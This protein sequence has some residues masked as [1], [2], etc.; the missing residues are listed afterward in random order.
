[1]YGLKR[2][3]KAY[4][5]A[6]FVVMS[7][8]QGAAADEI[9][10]D[11]ERVFG[12]SD[13]SWDTT[14]QASTVRSKTGTKSLAI[15][16]HSA[17]AGLSWRRIAPLATTGYAELRFWIYA[18]NISQLSLTTQ[19][20]DSGN[21]ST[22]VTFKPDANR[23]K[24]IVIPLS[25]LGNPSHIARLTIRNAGTL[26][27]LFYIDQLRLVSNKVQTKLTID[28][29]R[30]RKA[31]SPYIYGMSAYSA[32]SAN[33]QP[34]LKELKLPLLRFGGNHTSRYNWKLDTSN[35][36]ADWFFENIKLSNA[37]NLPA[38]SALNRF[39]NQNK[40]NQSQ[41]LLTIPMLGYLA[42]NDID[43]GFSISQ[44]GLQQ[45]HDVWRTNCGNG[46][47]TD[48]TTVTGNNPID[49]S[50][51]S[52]NAFAR[53]WVDYLKR[54]YGSS[55]ATGVRFYALDNEPDLWHGTHRDVAPNAI[56]Y[57]QLRD[58]TYQYA[59]AIK[60]ADSTAAVLGPVMAGWQSYWQSPY[61]LQNANL[62]PNDRNLHAGTALIPWYLQQM[63]LYEQV[64]GKRILDYLD[65]HYY[66]T[67]AGSI[68]GPVGDAA[69]QVT[70]LRST[71]ALW[72]STYMD[73]S[74]IAD[75]GIQ[76]DGIPAGV[77][78]L[79]PRMRKWV[80]D[81]YPGT[82]LSISE[83]NWGGLE[84]I[85]GALAQADV[86]GIFG[87]EGINLAM[88]F[89]GPK[90]TDPGAFAF[91]MFLNYNG[92]GGKFGTTS[93]YSYTTTPD[94]LAVYTAE[95]AS[96][97]GLTVMIINKSKVAITAPVSLSSWTP[98]SSAQVWRYGATN[99]KAIQK[100]A[101][102]VVAKTGWTGIFPAESITL[103][104]IPGKRG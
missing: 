15:Q 13:W 36:G 55:N 93:I 60:E 37:T 56:T 2:T 40:V 66:P 95:E 51:T 61:D 9:I 102:Q 70:R 33:T 41:S 52:T 10:Y 1:M 71:R 81:N 96:G 19:A 77:V 100:L 90:T 16:Y 62:P 35:A 5:F 98:S 68:A 64:N 7:L 24:E 53:E 78:S 75:I 92:I 21:D 80:Q 49:T 17:W 72:D 32:N 83:Y 88:L 54:R 48:G 11:D 47:R 69:T 99:T 42:K 91:R 38:D 57:D 73:E 20:S 39:I 50:L 63:K 46:I 101:N 67:L 82:G 8:T 59:T 29:S 58:T 27:P 12:W 44:Y 94:T 25:T 45:G 26:P 97:I 28:A 14:A 85:N 3:G 74:W 89:D 65:I 6:I 87:R 43:C 22:A 79:I 86:L 104:R 4:G 30:D 18:S 103:L 34:L 76:E 23:W 31:I 84:H